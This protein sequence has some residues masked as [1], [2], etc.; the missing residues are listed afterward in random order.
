MSLKAIL[1]TAG[2]GKRMCSQLPKALHCVG[3][4]PILAHFLETL[5]ALE[6][7]IIFVVHGF[8]GEQLQ[9]H[10]TKQPIHW[11]HQRE[12]LGT[13]HAVLQVL[14]NLQPSDQIL[15]LLGD[16]PLVLPE[17]LRNLQNLTPQNGLGIVT[18]VLPDPTG[19]GRIIR[20]A[21]GQITQ[22]VEQKDATAD[23]L[24]GNEINTGFMCVSAANL[25]RWLPQLQ[26]NNAQKEYYLPDIVKLA[27]A[28]GCPVIGVPVQSVNE[29]LGMNTR[30]QLAELERAHQ[31]RQVAALMATGV[32]VLDPARLDIRGEVS[33]G[34]DTVI[35]V[36]VILEG[37]VSI[38]PRCTIGPFVLLKNCTLAA[39][40]HV[41]A[42]SVIDG[43]QV[44]AKC[45][46][47]PFARLRPETE[48]KENV[49]I[50]NF[51]ELKKT[52]VNSGSKINH[53][54][55]MG[56]CQIG[57]LVNVGAGTITCNYD[58]AN[59]YATIIEDGAFIGSDTQLV[60][61]V[62]VGEGAT[63]AAGTTVIRD[64]PAHQLVMNKLERR[65]ITSWQRPKKESK[66][67]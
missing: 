32:T 16:M 33:V 46:I 21:T 9:Q 58:G 1:L 54:S 53:L 60:A 29:A 59:K 37:Q 15:I 38:G 19:F 44:G 17:T 43:C 30:A 26:N 34:Q 11:V 24:C 57:K 45:V 10:F 41:A 35:D 5:R 36:N 64:V 23:E 52:L 7:E 63:V 51:V 6:V 28:E 22:I 2:Q 56:D 3:G 61:P 42:H 39:D 50:G 18:A 49:H 65:T 27:V 31:K 13:A 55:Y 48:L 14:P 8:G 62:T 25:Q 47:G 40:V 67:N 66:V 4:K 12:Q 20:D